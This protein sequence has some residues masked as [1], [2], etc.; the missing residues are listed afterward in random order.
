MLTMAAFIWSKY[1]KN[2]NIVKFYD[3]LKY[4]MSIFIDLN[5]VFSI[6]SAIFSVTWSSEIMLICWFAAQEAFMI[7][8]NVENSC[9][10]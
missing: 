3:N 10:A 4:R 5:W 9:A 2:C 7:I 1:I 8:V 6:I